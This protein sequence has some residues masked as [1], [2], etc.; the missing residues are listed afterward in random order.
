MKLEDVAEIR[1]GLAIPKEKRTD[2]GILYIT[3]K[4][5]TEKGEIALNEVEYVSPEKGTEKYGLEKGDLLIVAAGNRMG[6]VVQWDMEQEAVFS[7][8]LFRVRPK[9]T[10]NGL[11]EKLRAKRD[12]LKGNLHGTALPRLS[13]KTLA[14]MEID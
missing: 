12:Y 9:K 10:S 3:S 2:A 4:N 6:Q 5:I 7:N 11:F 14:E 8:H 1:V 13:G